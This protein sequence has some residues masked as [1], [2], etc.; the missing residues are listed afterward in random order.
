MRKFAVTLLSLVL[1]VISLAAPVPAST[2]DRPKEKEWTLLVF[3]NGHNN[4]DPFGAADI[5]EMEKVGSTKD[6]NVVVQW[7]SLDHG[8]TRRLFVTKD[9]DPN[10][11]N[12]LVLDEMPAVDMGDYKNLVEF[13][14]WGA[15][16]Y[17][18]KKYFVDVWNHGSG[19][20]YLRAEMNRGG[21][22]ITDIS[23]DENTGNVITTEQLGQAMSEASAAIGKKIELYGSDACLMG[24]A[25][26]AAEM[27]DSVRFFAGSQELEPGDGWHYDRL[28]A[29]WTARP[30]VDGGGLGKILVASYLDGYGS[31]A[32]G[33]TLSAVNLEKL[34]VVESSIKALGAAIRAMPTSERQRILRVVEDSHSFYYR[35]YVDA[36]DFVKKLN[37][38]RLKGMDPSVLS[39]LGRSLSEYVVASGTSQDHA[40]ATG[41]SIWIP[42][43]TF[44]YQQYSARYSGLK[45]SQ[46]TGW[47][48]TL[49]TLF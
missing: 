8:K 14:R 19:W 45:F 41:V 48:D 23:H 10:A 42:S 6:I 5:N 36:G 35:D 1:P 2:E 27:S 13:I 32:D 12:S 49:K 28:L 16:N 46:R 17:P 7:A 44:A 39:D 25:E 47:A 34:P 43:S 22:S 15:K 18:A 26:V 24:M 4:L 11:V 20:H 40:D 33:L 30:T 3:L 21:I 31:S 37:G 9:N 29:E 38:A